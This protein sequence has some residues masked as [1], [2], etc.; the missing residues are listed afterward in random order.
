MSATP[1]TP[2]SKE[3]LTDPSKTPQFFHHP[4]KTRRLIQNAVR[5][6]PTGKFFKSTHS[7]D[8]VAVT[9]LPDGLTHYI[10]GGLSYVR[11]GGDLAETRRRG[12]I[13]DFCLYDDDPFNVIAAKLLWGTCGVDGKQPYKLVLL[14]DCSLDHLRA[15]LK[16]QAQIAGTIYAKVVSYWVDQKSRKE[17]H[18]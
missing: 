12:L 11:S 16:T 4:G 18:S 9:G 5:C 1:Q 6:A 15:I 10:D 14:K 3:V 8:F 17:Q 2:K 7:H 13:E